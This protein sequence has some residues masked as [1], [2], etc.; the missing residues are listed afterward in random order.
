M[1]NR[2]DLHVVHK[3]IN[4]LLTIWD[5]ERGLFF[6]AL[7]VGGVTFNFLTRQKNSWVSSG[8]GRLPSE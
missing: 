4:R 7:V 2:P 8:S 1:S 5:A 3:S 6:L